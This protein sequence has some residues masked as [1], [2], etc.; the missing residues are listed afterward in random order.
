VG[1][2]YKPWFYEQVRSR[3]RSGTT[4]EVVPLQDYYHRHNRSIFW[5]SELLVPFGNHPAFRYLLGWLMPPKVS[6]LKL[7]ESKSVRRLNEEQTVIQDDIVPLRCL[8]ETIETAHQLFEVYPLWLAPV[9]LVRRQRDCMVG[10]TGVD[11]EMYVDVGIYFSVPGPVRR[12]EPWNYRD[13]L[14]RYE[15]WLREHAAFQAPHSVTRMDRDGYRAMFDC[16]P[17]DRVRHDYRAENVF[18]DA[19]EKLRRD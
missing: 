3:L 9:R 1:R 16:T 19:Y 10:P 4:T 14:S 17:Y 7:T 2:W 15:A 5:A 6:F 13:A 12:G 8:R 11:E 18:L